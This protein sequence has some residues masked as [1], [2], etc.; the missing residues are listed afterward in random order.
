MNKR[1]SY[2]K[3]LALYNSNI[4]FDHAENQLFST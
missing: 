2:L 1:R 3:I 4:P